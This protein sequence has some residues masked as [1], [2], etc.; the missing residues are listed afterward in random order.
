MGCFEDFIEFRDQVEKTK[1][2]RSGTEIGSEK[3]VGSEKEIASHEHKDL[4]D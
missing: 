1:K 2:S 3:E 4:H